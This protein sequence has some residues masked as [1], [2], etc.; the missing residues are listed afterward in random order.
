MKDRILKEYEIDNVKCE[1]CGSLN[2]RIDYING[3]CPICKRSKLTETILFKMKC[4]RD[5]CVKLATLERLECESSYS[6]QNAIEIQ[7]NILKILKKEI[8]EIFDNL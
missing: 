5:E 3:I 7:N 2:L 8:D 4:Y 6:Y 1:Y